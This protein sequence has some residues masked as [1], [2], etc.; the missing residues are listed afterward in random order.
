MQ[1][2]YQFMPHWRAGVRHDAL[3]SGTVAIGL[4]NSG[5]L[6]FAD[7]PQLAAHNPKRNTAMLDY[8]PSEYTRFRLQFARDD[9]GIG[10]TDNQLFLQYIFSLGAHGAHAF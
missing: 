8:S 7:F 5:M 4:V 6:S 1:G 9:S 10:A 3:K 2:V